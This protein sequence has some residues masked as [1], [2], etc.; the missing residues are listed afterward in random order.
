MNVE[1]N[2]ISFGRS[3]VKGQYRC[4]EARI[5]EYAQI[6]VYEEYDGR[7]NST[8]VINTSDMAGARALYAW[9]HEGPHERASQNAMRTDPMIRSQLERTEDRYLGSIDD[10]DAQLLSSEL[11]PLLS[12]FMRIDW[13]GPAVATKILHLHKP[14]LIPVID[15]HVLK[16]YAGRGTENLSKPEQARLVLD[17]VDQIRVTLRDN[18]E[19]FKGLAR[20]LTNLPIPLTRTRMHDILVWSIWKWDLRNGPLEGCAEKGRRDVTTLGCWSGN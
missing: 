1:P 7:H 9:Y 11:G 4:P 12:L 19:E 17:T 6:E 5:R 14:D 15:S 8:N 3:F 10:K 20:R 13:V 2:V 18:Q 16:F